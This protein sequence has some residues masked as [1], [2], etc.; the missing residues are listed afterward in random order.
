MKVLFEKHS[1]L[2]KCVLVLFNVLFFCLAAYLLP[3][4]FETNDDIDMCLTANGC[5]TGTPDC[6]LI[7]PN[8]LYGCF[9]AWLYTLT[10]A[11]EWYTV[12]FAMFHV[13]SVS[14]IVWHILKLKQPPFLKILLLLFVYVIWLNLIIAFQFTTTAALLAIAGCF[15]CLQG[16]RSTV[17]GILL[18][19]MASLVRFQAA[20]LVG[21]LFV[22]VV[23]FRNQF[24]WRKYI[25]YIILLSVVLLLKRADGLF[26]QST[27]WK[28]FTERNALRGGIN[29]N[30][31]FDKIDF[32][33]LK[34]NGINKNNYLLL[35]WFMS[36]GATMG[37]EQLKTIKQILDEMP[38]EKK[39]DNA[40]QLV[41][42]R[43]P[44]A[45][46]LLFSLGLALSADKKSDRW[47]V[48]VQTFFFFATI[49]GLGFD[50]SV[51]YR[52]FLS[53]FFAS[54]L[55]LSLVPVKKG[56][57]VW[58]TLLI[59]VS[60]LGIS[61]KYG[62]RTYKISKSKHQMIANEWELKQKPLMEALPD[63]SVYGG[64]YLWIDLVNPFQIK[65]LKLRPIG[66]CS[67]P[68]YE[69]Y[70][71]THPSLLLSDNFYMFSGSD[72]HD[73]LIQLLQDYM[74]EQYSMT[75]YVD[76]I[77]KKEPFCVLQFKQ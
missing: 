33:K 67:T 30:P 56:T 64:Y 58:I 51:K 18:I 35:G 1:T 20:G 44:L 39:Y 16:K 12:V 41:L 48:V 66:L 14:I 25:P 6:H 34:E 22:P 68:L 13:I 24:E 77:I 61:C 76:T 21:L 62:L 59:T 60:L 28:N 9:I 71:L 36:D 23:I 57:P 5:Q 54:V 37:I 3:I 45:L 55:F 65:S 27:E 49:I 31:N 50:H 46:L 19:I 63:R 4:L 74:Q 75:L 40:N 7:Y 43:V 42:Y 26:Y 53:A 52:V 10:T 15:A 72:E 73:E 70:P 32:E 38:V 47:F 8:A 17:S 2:S 29:D 69:H 11:V